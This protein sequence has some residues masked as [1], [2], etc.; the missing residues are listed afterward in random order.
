[1]MPH[2]RERQ[3][4][5]AALTL[6]L[7]G[8]AETVHV[9]VAGTDGRRL[10]DFLLPP[11]SQPVLPVPEPPHADDDRDCRADILTVLREAG[12]RLTADQILAELERRQWLWGERTVKGHL[13]DMVADGT[14][15]NS[16]GAR[17]RGYRPAIG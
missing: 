8:L 6:L 14:L 1:M 4:L 3:A 15:D 7:D 10:A 13:G 11:S 16:T 2:E 17:P 5:L 9:T 12:R